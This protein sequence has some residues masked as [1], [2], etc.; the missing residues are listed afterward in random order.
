[1]LTGPRFR[2]APIRRKLM[3]VIMATTATAMLLACFGILVFDSVLFRANLGRDLQALAQITAGNS[4]AS[5]EFNDSKSASETLNALQARLHL[6]TACLYEVDGTMLARYV[7][8]SNPEPCP[9]PVRYDSI[10][11][12]DRDATVSYN[13]SMSGKPIGT[14]MFL[15]DLREIAERRQLYGTIVAGVLLVAGLIALL[16]SRS[17]RHVIEDPIAQLVKVTTAVAETGDYGIRARKVSE[18]ELG[19]LTDGFN[20]ML[21]GIQ[22]RDNRLTRALIDREEALRDEKKARERF[23]FLAE[24]M[25]QKIFTA[26]P[27]GEVN[28]F[29]QQWIQ[30]S[31]LSSEELR[32][33]GWAVILHPDDLDADE[34]IRARSLET[35]EPYHIQHRFRRADGE[36][37]WH[38]TRVHAMRDEE[39]KILMWIG[40]NTD[41]HEQKE[42]EEALRRA[43]DDLQQFAY[44]ASHD[45]QEPIRNVT[46][47][48]EIVGRRYKDVLDADGQ[49]F[50]GFLTEGGRRMAMLINDLLAYTRAGAADVDVSLQDSNAV[51]QQ[52]LAG[53]AEAVRESGATVTHDALPQIYIGQAHLQQVLQN[54]ISNAIKYRA[55]EPPRIHISAVSVGAAWQFSVKDNGIGI[56]PQYREKI[57]GVFK[58]LHRDQKYSGTGVGLAI[59][60]RVVERYG[61]RIWVESSVGHGATFHFTIPRYAGRVRRAAAERP[62]G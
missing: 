30:F 55:D 13:I 14:L 43:N 33:L 9:P 25:P 57:F 5:L 20:E 61:G 36:Y 18:D 59:C 11:F 37:R 41:I 42:R 56:D 2:D 6:V 47:Y 32:H 1:M 10:R 16:I 12:G 45:L 52:T 38:L 4:T 7:R 50:L 48:S 62:D 39:G 19:L 3:L 22:S 24:S 51:L 49:Q 27:E 26:T 29:N 35:G 46:I 54:L 8:P 17:L 23:R 28:Y 40:S 31:G 15:Y 58:R 53:L 60:Q 34:E 21:A 44:S